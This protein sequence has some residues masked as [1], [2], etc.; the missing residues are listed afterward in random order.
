M[1]DQSLRPNLSAVGGQLS[2][3]VES[4]TKEQLLAELNASGNV[5]IDGPSLE[6][7]LDSLIALEAQEQGLM[8]TQAMLEDLSAHLL[9]LATQQARIHPAFSE[10]II[11]ASKALS[12]AVRS[13]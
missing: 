9:R 6:Q 7:M 8:Q 13:V 5:G 10:Q 4:R 12:Q 3:F 11:V 2:A 1:A